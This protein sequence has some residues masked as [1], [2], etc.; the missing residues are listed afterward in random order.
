MEIKI[1]DT[2]TYRITRQDRKYLMEA[3]RIYRDRFYRHQSEVSEDTWMK[4][5]AI[6]VHLDK[7]HSIIQS[8]ETE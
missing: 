4:N 7:L 2:E 5:R 3:L 8:I 6:F 1:N